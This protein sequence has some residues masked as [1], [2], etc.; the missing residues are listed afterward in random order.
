MA[1]AT[2]APGI[3]AS[4]HQML[5]IQFLTLRSRK[6]PDDFI[7]TKKGTESRKVSDKAT[8]SCVA[9]LQSESVT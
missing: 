8:S 6:L 9:A 5:L 4:R 3:A 1:A 7:R 2:T